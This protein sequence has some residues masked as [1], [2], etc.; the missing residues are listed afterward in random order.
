MET[1]CRSWKASRW[2]S[3]R[4]HWGAGGLESTG[5]ALQAS[6]SPP[7]APAPSCLL[8]VRIP[9]TILLSPFISSVGSPAYSK[10]GARSFSRHWR[11]SMLVW[12]T[13][14]QRLGRLKELR[15]TNMSPFL[16]LPSLR[17]FITSSRTGGLAVAVS[18]ITG[19]APRGPSCSCWKALPRS[20]YE[21][22]KSCPH[23]ET[24][25]AS[26]TAS[27]HTF[28][29]SWCRRHRLSQI[30]TRVSGQM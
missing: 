12:W 3:V 14:K 7:A 8:S 11:L 28:P 22:R 13:V 2:G 29:C 20:R 18:A 15:H 19:I 25:W 5:T 27:R 6:S 21:G 17:I 10:Y 16:L 26:S 9:A 4:H 30:L 24:Q 1:R 23:L